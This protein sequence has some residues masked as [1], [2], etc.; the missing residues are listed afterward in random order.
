[1]MNLTE[2]PAER[3]FRRR[4]R[5]WLA[6]NLPEG[7]AEGRRA[8]PRRLQERFQFRHAWHKRLN[9]GGWIGL[10]WPVEYGGKGL[11]S[12]EQLIFHEE[13]AKAE[14]PPV[15]NWVG[16]ELVAPSLMRWGSDEQKRHFLPRIMSGEH[17]WC[18]AWSEPGA[19]SDLTAATTRAERDGD[20]FVI[21]GRKRWISWAQFAT[22]AAVLVRTGDPALRHKS[23]SCLI[24][25]LDTPGITV[26]P[27]PM[28][29]GEAEEN[30]VFFE[31]VR[32]P[33]SALF[34]PLNGGWSVV[35]TAM[36]AARGSTSL[37]RIVDLQV[38][39]GKMV[40]Q[41][42]SRAGNRFLL[43]DSHLRRR[44]ARLEARLQGL[45]YLAYRKTA[46]IEA[47]EPDG[48]AGS[49]EKLLWSELSQEL[50]E[51]ALHLEGPR[52]L[53]GG[54]VEEDTWFGHWREAYMRA[55][56]T[57]VEGGTS[58]IQRNTIARRVLRL[59]S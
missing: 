45:K 51:V 37:V 34:G 2:T 14:A 4:V 50:T 20:D 9:E 25:P 30:D 7:W 18:Q 58:E 42:A 10:H 8:E 59:A 33:A 27:I 13:M 36:A 1:M 43:D 56:G 57:S 31:N 28:L 3:E 19:G 16:I 40:R 11:S 38:Q 22:H 41:A 47:G 23:L 5:S 53:I 46:E 35:L 21:N 54:H 52:V 6:D 17:V 44:L 32:V 48:A 39:L 29:N 49:T 55:K 26:R 24:V 15:A 12:V